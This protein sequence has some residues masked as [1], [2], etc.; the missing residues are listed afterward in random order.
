MSSS[1]PSRSQAPQAPSAGRRIFSKFASPLFSQKGRSIA[2][3]HIKAHDP[4]KQYSPGESVKG[5]V[6]VKVVKPV[7]VTHVSV[8]LHGFAQ[9][10]RSPSA[11]ADQLRGNTN[12]IGR[13]QGRGKKSGEYFGN[14]FAS[15]FEDE[16]VLC[17]DGRLDEGVYRFDFEV[18][19]PEDMELPSSIDFERG[20]ISYML[21]AT[22]TR[23]TTIAPVIS[24]DQKIYLVERVDIAPLLPPKP[25]TITLEPVS[26][27]I[28]PPRGPS[29][30]PARTS[31]SP[32]HE[33]DPPTPS[34][35]EF[36]LDSRVSSSQSDTP[37]KLI[38]ATVE[39][40][41]GACLRGDS[42]PVRISINHTK[43]IKSIN[44]IIITLYRQAR[45]DMHPALPLGPVS[46][47]Q[48][49]K[50]EDYYPKSITGLGGLSLSGAGSSHT[51][52]K[53]LAQILVPLYVDP[54]SLTAE[55]NA[56]IG[57][58]HGAFPTI[59]SVPGAMISFR[60]YI[61]IVLDIQGKLTH[62]RYLSQHGSGPVSANTR[63]GDSKENSLFNGPDDTPFL[64]LNGAGILDTAPIRR[65]KS[66]ATCTFEVVVGTADSERNA[67][68]GKAK[69]VDIPLPPE[70]TS[71]VTDASPYAV[72]QQ[73]HSTV[74]SRDFESYQHVDGYT[75]DHDH[76]AHLDYQYVPNYDYGADAYHWDASQE[77]PYDE[78]YHP[79][80]YEPPALEDEE[81]LPEKERLRRAEARL[82]PSQPPPM[83]SASSGAEEAT[84]PALPVDESYHDYGP[85]VAGSSQSIVMPSR[86]T[87]PIPIPILRTDNTTVQSGSSHLPPTDDKHEL[88]R[89]QL[90]LSTSAPPLPTNSQE[91]ENIESGP[92]APVIID[93]D[94]NEYVLGGNAEGGASENLPRY[95]R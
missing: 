81:T 41:K 19:F 35:S 50:Y 74:S 71:H 95:R 83:A 93:D 27:K 67:R 2:D 65:D 69:A 55:I 34:L 22:L 6:V 57:V 59:T 32:T 14:G 94:L 37:H 4:H 20:T 30:L 26:R 9:V 91:E 36:S 66:V 10:Y 7:R 68:K 76:N 75:Y 63:P 21:T 90:E 16:S 56:K 40:L 88:Q 79:A 39:L 25:R 33:A 85:A 51:F 31:T 87:Q 54:I 46:E 78:S 12:R 48:K 29:S 61:E 5:A 44:G 43:H 15:L 42:F 23:P 72:Q 86:A 38:T 17:G 49:R 89:R 64:M 18:Q 1:S 3:F 77:Y 8:C 52:R 13:A 58:P 82:M 47:G 60:Y 80:Y 28:K 62:D 73:G 24:H 70:N 92:S 53:D 84:A 45:V 11:T